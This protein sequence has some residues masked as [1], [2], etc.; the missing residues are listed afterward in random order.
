MEDP[1]LEEDSFPQG[2]PGEASLEVR[3]EEASL[4]VPVEEASSGIFGGGSLFGGSR[5]TPSFG[6]FGDGPSFPSFGSSG[7]TPFFGGFG[8]RPSFGG[9]PSFGS[10]GSPAPPRPFQ[11]PRQDFQQP[12]FQPPYQ[13]P[14]PPTY[15]PV[16]PNYR[17][18]APTRRPA[19]VYQQPAAPA[20]R[21][22]APT[23][24]P[25][26][27]AFRPAAP[28]SRPVIVSQRPV[29]P[30][31]RPV[32]V[33]QRPVAP[34]FRPAP[35]VQPS[36]PSQLATPAFPL[37]PDVIRDNPAPSMIT[38]EVS[39]DDFFCGA[40][41]ISDQHLLTAAHCV[42]NEYKRPREVT[43]R[44]VSLSAGG[45]R[46]LSVSYEIENVILHP[47]YI[48]DSVRYHDLAI[49][50]TRTRVQFGPDTWPYC[51]PPPGTR[52]DF[53]TLTV[54]GWGKVN[55][56]YTAENLQQ[57]QV[58][59]IPNA[60]C[61]Q[62]YKRAELGEHLE[63]RYPQG[64]TDNLICAGQ[65]GK[66]ACEGDSGGPLTYHDEEGREILIGVVST[67]L[68]CGDNPLLPGIYVNVAKYVDWINSVIY[69]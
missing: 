37:P 62:D 29:A 52:V 58:P 35:V 2:P 64:L 49:L 40:S 18:A 50:K 8:G 51:L 65:L 25:A 1:Y 33:S 43:F 27:P 3:V 22:A 24:R 14:Y 28:T 46:V 66:D 45:D 53:K 17:P 15:Q 19:I 56:S 32:I 31:S 67:G 7:D 44:E 42:T 11:I 12:F 16:R 69:E 23:F 39:L 59:A 4:E 20:F 36:T 21:P 47:E 55:S 38:S 63:L 60:I 10:F 6:G 68:P 13:P 9:G 26:A 5:G 34:T 57:A 54:S 30:T 48:E 41:L 61:A